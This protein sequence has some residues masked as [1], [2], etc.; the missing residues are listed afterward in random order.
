GSE[1]QRSTA[2]VLTL[3][4]AAQLALW[5]TTTHIQSRFLMPLIIPSAPLIALPL[6]RLL[7]HIPSSASVALLGVL[8][9]TQLAYSTRIFAA[10]NPGTA[11]ELFVG[12]PESQTG[13]FAR[14]LPP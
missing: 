4:L 3:C 1:S 6:P 12:G 14:A 10:Q 8:P 9:L 7:R 11:Y 13:E 2:L 5:L